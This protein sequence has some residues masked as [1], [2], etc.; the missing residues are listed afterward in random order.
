MYP[1]LRRFETEVV[2]MTSWMLHGDGNVA[3][4]LTSG[5]TES[6][7]LAVKTYRDRARALRPNIARPN[8]IAPITVHPAFEKAAHYFDVEIIHVSVDSTYRVNIA[9]VKKAI[10]RNTILLIGSAP[11]YCH[12]VVD[13]IEALSELALSK[14]LPLHVDACFGGFML[15]WLEKLGYPIPLFDFRVSGVTSIS[16]DVHKY[17]YTSKGASVILYRNSE[18]RSY[19]YFAY[20]SWPGGLFGSP[21]LTGSRPGGA[22]AAAWAALVSMGQNGYLSIAKDVMNTTQQIIEG[23]EKTNCLGILTKPDMTCVAI[24]SKNKKVNIHAVADLMEQKGWKIERQQ[25]PDSIHM[26]VLPQH[27]RIVTQ[28]VS[29]LNECANLVL[30]QPELNNKG[31]TGIYGMVAAIPDHAILDDF[32]IKFFNQIYSTDPKSLLEDKN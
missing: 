21:S 6:I 28:L 17:G 15:P 22:I 32:I 3:G 23:V 13:P 27:K 24:V 9:E 11:Q 14:G 26:S 29:D 10:N 20:A 5:G 8:M 2:S 4:S 18:L 16:A 31:S 1:S 25:Y 19:Q 7:L 30:A 12:G